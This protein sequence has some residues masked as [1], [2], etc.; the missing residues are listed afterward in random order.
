[1]KTH[2]I[3]PQVAEALSHLD[4][5]QQLKLLE[6]INALIGPDQYRKEKLLEFAGSIEPADLNLMEQA[7]KEADKTD[8][9]E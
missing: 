2:T 6:F 8:E 1:M 5:F 3:H 7:I 4:E 9:D